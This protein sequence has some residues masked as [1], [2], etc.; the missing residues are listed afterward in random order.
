[1]RQE[2][3]A[4]F[5][6]VIASLTDAK[7][8][9][10]LVDEVYAAYSDSDK[11]QLT[12]N[13]IET[14]TE[15]MAAVRA[16]SA[17]ENPLYFLDDPPTAIFVTACDKQKLNVHLLG[18][19]EDGEKALSRSMDDGRIILNAGALGDVAGK[20]SPVRRRGIG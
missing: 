2:I 17:G 1:M 18:L 19:E 20:A 10:Q 3:A 7:K 15:T 11:D 6:D 12:I 13:L 5:V 16:G 8:V 9:R 14:F 4:K